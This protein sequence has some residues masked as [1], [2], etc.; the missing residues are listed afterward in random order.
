MAKISGKFGLSVEQRPVDQAELE[1][2]YDADFEAYVGRLEAFVRSPLVKVGWDKEGFGIMRHRDKEIERIRRE[3]R[4]AH[5]R[6][7]PTLSRYRALAEAR[8]ER[9][10]ARWTA[11][12]V[13]R[14]Q[15]EGS[16]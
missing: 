2:A 9:A 7:A 15:P 6:V 12:L 1:A 11:Q 4:D 10:L 3:R 13:L 8:R 16:A 14:S 5:E